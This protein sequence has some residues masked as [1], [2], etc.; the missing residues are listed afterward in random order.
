ML[1]SLAVS[2]FICAIFASTTPLSAAEN[3]SRGS[4]DET[5]IVLSF[6]AGSTD[7]GANEILDILREHEIRTTVFVTGDFIRR[8]PDVVRRIVSDGHEVGNHTA[9]HPRFTTY[10]KN[11][12]QTTLPH[13]T[14][15]LVHRQLE[16]AEKLFLETT[17]V[18][19]SKY[20]RAPYGEHNV[21]IRGWAAELGYVHV[22]WTSG[23]KVNLDSLDWVTNPRSP[24]YLSGRNVADRLI[25]F[26]LTEESLN[27]GIILM[28]LG[29]DR[30]EDQRVAKSLPRLIDELRKKGLR[31][32]TVS[33]LEA[34][35]SD[36]G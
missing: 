24:R 15:E 25:R 32:V 9:T 5:K 33:E 3:F 17:G 31:F 34:D 20:W 29:T 16:E 23:P 36:A 6:D 11:R 19:M 28:H 4:S 7:K 1:R 26:A 12:K 14:R 13:V 35:N 22:G 8:Y 10:A 27:G 21:E 2:L 30:P 18:P